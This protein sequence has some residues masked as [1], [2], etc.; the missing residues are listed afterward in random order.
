MNVMLSSADVARLDAT[1]RTLLA[2]F[3][4]PTADEWA[5]AVCGSARAL[6]QADSA[7]FTLPSA[8]GVSACNDGGDPNALKEY[9]L[10]HAADD[11]TFD[12]L[13]ELGLGPGSAV[14]YTG[15]QLRA[16]GAER[17]YRS[18]VYN[19]Y[20]VPNRWLDGTGLGLRG[21]D[22][23]PN[24]WLAL[25]YEREG[26]E[27]T[28]DRG[29]AL[30]RLLLPA[31]EAV[32]RASLRLAQHRS[33]LGQL[34]DGLAAALFVCDETGRVLHQNPA[35]ARMLKVEPE[36]NRLRAEVER[37]AAALMSLRTARTKTRP[38]WPGSA[39][40]REVRTASGRYRLRGN[41]LG[42]GMLGSAVVVVSVDRL[43]AKPFSDDALRTRF[44]LTP[45]E[46]TI[47]QLL[48]RGR[49]N[50][51]IARELGFTVHTAERHTEHILMKLGVHSR[52]AV[53][54]LVLGTEASDESAPSC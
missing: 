18:R 27:Y 43:S 49:T 47:A 33:E 4:H 26:G 22:G 42:S 45:R 44:R 39:C 41:F 53:A 23:T 14:A 48:A 10:H 51:E 1:L 36:Y 5:S 52:A 31:F 40:V 32:L 13:T 30:L 2:P 35:A 50:A 11:P 16:V 21:P 15:P 54:S 29:L 34:L 19:E 20:Y 3:D 24:G 28:G 17:W 8:T 9:V 25:T 37:V 6:L 7:V 12:R 38:D 46:I